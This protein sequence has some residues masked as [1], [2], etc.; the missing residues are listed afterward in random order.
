MASEAPKRFDQIMLDEPVRKYL[1][2]HNITL[3][4]YLA[5]EAEL[6]LLFPDEGTYRRFV[7]AYLTSTG[8]L[9]YRQFLKAPQRMDLFLHPR[10]IQQAPHIHDFFEIKYMLS[11]SGTVHIGSDM[12]FL[13]ET[14]FCIISPYVPHSSEIYSDEATMLNLV[15]PAEYVPELFPRLLSFQNPLRT[16]FSREHNPRLDRCFLFIRAGRDTQLQTLMETLLDD[17]SG[18]KRRSAVGNLRAEAALEQAFLRLLELQMSSVAPDVFSADAEDSR[19]AEM[20]DYM[21]CHLREVSLGNIAALFHFS[22]PYT[23]RYIK[24]KTGYTFQMILLIFRMEEAARL[25]QETA[26]PIDQIAADVGLSG[27]TNFYR[28][29]KS[30]YGMSPAAF[31]ASQRSRAT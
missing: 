19:I 5:H 11:G 25:L 29:F 28:Q 23:S 24:R 13:Q 20:A 22:Q 26:W 21:R 30:F 17:F 7:T 18:T 10:Y 2:E 1:Y 27:K 8:I 31:R 12:L 15:V 9:S 14:D 6:M 3:D 16:Y 4:N